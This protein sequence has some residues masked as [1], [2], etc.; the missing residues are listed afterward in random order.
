MQKKKKAVTVYLTSLKK[1]K[2][3]TKLGILEFFSIERKLVQSFQ[4]AYDQNHNVAAKYPVLVASIAP[5]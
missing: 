5:C 2:T 3:N 4:H 1:K